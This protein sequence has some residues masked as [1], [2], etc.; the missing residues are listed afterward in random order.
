MAESA[1]I[2]AIE[3]P[4]KSRFLSAQW[5]YLVML[6]YEIEP[7]LLLASLP[8]GTELDF[9]NGM[10]FLSVVGFLFADTM[11]FGLP[12]PFHRNF[13]EVNLRFYVRRR[14][15]DGVRR[16]VAFIKEIVP[17]YAIAAIARRR[18]HENYVSLPMKHRL[19]RSEDTDTPLE[20]EYRWRFRGAWNQVGAAI[21]GPNREMAPGSL[22]EFIAEHYW[23]YTA[24]PDGGCLEYRV[25]HSRWNIWPAERSWLDCD[26]AG[27]YGKK[28]EGTLGGSPVSAFVADGSAVSVYKGVRI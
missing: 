12:I 21:S 10:T 13:E 19:V 11:V 6:N 24:Q 16:G 1:Q 18:Y 5:R 3:A 20:V 23:G 14:S 4:G 2:T 15:P 22:D 26:V 7:D 27:L 8:A 9:Y 17:R 25:E 28:F